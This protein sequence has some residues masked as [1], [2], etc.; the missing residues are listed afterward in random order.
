MWQPEQPSS[1]QVPILILSITRPRASRSGGSRTTR[2]FVISS[3]PHPFSAIAP[4]GQACTHLPQ[5]VQ[6]VASP[7]GRR[8]SETSCE[9]MPRPATSHTCAPSISAQVRT[10]R[11]H[12][13]QRLWSST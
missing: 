7:H 5:L 11:E 3:T 12:S 6:V 13:T 2:C 1:Q 4:V 9:P 10:Q 8:S